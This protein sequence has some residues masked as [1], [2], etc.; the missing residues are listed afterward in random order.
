M[1]LK[2]FGTSNGGIIFV[3]RNASENEYLTFSFSMKDDMW[4]H[5]KDCPGSHVLLRGSSHFEDVHYAAQKAAEHSKFKSAY[6][7]GKQIRVEYCNILDVSKPKH[8]QLGQVE[9][10]NASTL[11][12]KKQNP[13]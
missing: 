12:V 13:I 1:K 4:F 11:S 8:G 10:C 3:G 5:V 9:I 2:S 7:N 6:Q